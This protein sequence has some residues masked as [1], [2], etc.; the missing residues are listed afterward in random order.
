[1]SP[2]LKPAL[3][4]PEAGATLQAAAAAVGLT[5]QRLAELALVSFPPIASV[6][7]TQEVELRDVGESLYRRLSDK[8]LIEER[9][10]L[11]DGLTTEQKTI[12]VLWLCEQGFA[13]SSIAQ[14][15]WEETRIRRLWMQRSEDLGKQVQGVSLQVLVGAIQ[16]RYEQVTEMAKKKGDYRAM[17]LFEKDRVALLQ[18]LGVVEQAVRRH[19]IEVTHKVEDAMQN[20]LDRILELRE[21][22]K[23]RELAWEKQ[24]DFVDAEVVAG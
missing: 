18:S 8:K 13:P 24:E 10:A 2:P 5:P 9:C 15:G 17:M 22:A 4:E 23:V 14:L 3:A 21:K 16:S 1:M 7:M 11:F 6:G 19:S 12:L 20:E